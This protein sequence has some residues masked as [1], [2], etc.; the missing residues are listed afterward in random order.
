[1]LQADANRFRIDTFS[2][3]LLDYHPT[4]ALPA[5]YE[6]PPDGSET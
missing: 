2:G 1:M 3:Q 5:D 6:S 4:P